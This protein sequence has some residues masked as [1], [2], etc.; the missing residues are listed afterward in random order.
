LSTPF[1]LLGTLGFRQDD[2]KMHFLNFLDFLGTIVFAVS[3]ALGAGR[4]HLD[5][6]GTIVVAFVTAVGG[7]TLRDLLL[8]L[9]PVFWI[10]R[11]IYVIVPALAATITFI[12]MRHLVFPV[13]W[14]LVLDA[15]GLGVFTVLGCER[16]ATIN[17]SPIIVM[18]M[19]MLSGVAGGAIRDI[20]CDEIPLVLRS[21]I[22]ATAALA[23]GAAFCALTALKLPQPLV[24]GLAACIVIVLRLGAIRL[25]VSLPVAKQRSDG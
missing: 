14:L 8:G 22:Y 21:E 10:Q 4:K 16:A 15:L 2:S 11:P 5:A 3:G 17:S 24:L 9:T 12:A 7:G 18:I 1:A 23:G 6:F 19:G 13:R 20:L 25:Q